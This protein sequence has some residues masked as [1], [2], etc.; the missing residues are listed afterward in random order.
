MSEYG[1]EWREKDGDVLPPDDFDT[2]V[3]EPYSHE[4]LLRENNIPSISESRWAAQ[5]VVEAEPEH[6]ARFDELVADIE[7]GL[8]KS[9]GYAEPKVEL[10]GHMVVLGEYFAIVVGK[11][12]SLKQITKDEFYELK[13]RYLD[14]DPRSRSVSRQEA[15]VPEAEKEGCDCECPICDGG[16]G[17][18]CHNERTGCYI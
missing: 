6:S 16:G 5:R 15:S 12:L 13:S 3:D 17:L 1:A 7:A 18:H 10:S 2:G 4:R 9:L 8:E 11:A 14:R